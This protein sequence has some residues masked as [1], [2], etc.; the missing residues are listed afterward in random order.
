MQ[1]VEW[2]AVGGAGW[3]QGKTCA[4]EHVERVVHGATACHQAPLETQISA[5]AMLT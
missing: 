3:R 4:C 5:L 2:H 1:T